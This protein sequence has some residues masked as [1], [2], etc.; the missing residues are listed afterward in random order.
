[1]PK[2][3][4]KAQFGKKHI[5]LI[6]VTID[7]DVLM[8]LDSDAFVISDQPKLVYDD[9]T[10]SILNTQPSMS[11]FEIGRKRYDWY[12]SVLLLSAGLCPSLIDIGKPINE[13][14]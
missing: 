10:C 1:M 4:Q 13:L 3:L 11:L 8:I 12:V 7:P 6:D 2:N 9:L 5:P 14:E